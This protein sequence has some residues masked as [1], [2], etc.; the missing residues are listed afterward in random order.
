MKPIAEKDFS[1]ET[2]SL[3][4][5]PSP[6]STDRPVVGNGFGLPLSSENLENGEEYHSQHETKSLEEEKA[7]QQRNWRNMQPANGGQRRAVLLLLVACIASVSVFSLINFSRSEKGSPAGNGFSK[8]QPF[9]L[10]HPNDLGITSVSRPKET[11]PPARL[12]R[13]LESPDS[14]QRQPVP[15]SAWYQNLLLSKGEPSNLI[16]AYAM[17]YMLDL[18]GPIPGLTLHTSFLV[19]TDRVVQL[20]N[21]APFGLTLGAAG[22]ISGKSLENLSHQ[23]TVSSPT[24]LGVTLHWV[25]TKILSL[26]SNMY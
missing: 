23:Y 16:R 13:R 12:F 1:T 9:S 18:V 15:T 26:N 10:I 17:P 7:W 8:P 11:A 4:T 3:L 21:N 24:E 14:E 6:Q 22:D 2:T 25:R 5:N 19:P 20:T